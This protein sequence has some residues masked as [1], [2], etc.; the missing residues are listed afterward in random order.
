MAPK[1]QPWERQPGETDERWR[2]FTHYRDLPKRSLR[3][4]AEDLGYADLSLVARWSQE[5]G[6]VARVRAWDSHLDQIALRQREIEARDAARRHAELARDGL[7]AAAMPLAALLSDRKVPLEGGGFQTIPRAADLEEM[8]T[9]DLVY[10]ARSI[11]RLV[12]GL[13]GVER[14]SRDQ[15]TEITDQRGRGGGETINLFEDE[16]RTANLLEGL[17]D[18]GLLNAVGM[19]AQRMMR[20]SEPKI[21][22]AD[23][24]DVHA[25]ADA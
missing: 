7:R 17:D 15:P 9:S 23:E 2:G 20:A 13:V 16:E 4:C 3:Q 1:P 6:W 25:P 19:E 24:A 10:L 5:D 8:K 14:L 21:V 12:P 22:E 11:V 18:L